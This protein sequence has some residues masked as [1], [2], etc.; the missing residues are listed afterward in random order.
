[1]KQVEILFNFMQLLGQFQLKNL[2]LMLHFEN[3]RRR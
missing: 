3:V 2:E 1:M